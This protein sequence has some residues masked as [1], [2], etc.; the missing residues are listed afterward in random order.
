MP[1]LELNPT[2]VRVF[3]GTPTGIDE[4][5]FAIDITTG[6]LYFTDPLTGTWTLITIGGAASGSS[7]LDF[8]SI[9]DGTVAELTFTVTGAAVND[10]I[11]PSWPSTLDTGLVGM[12]FVS[13][14]DTVTVRLLNMSGAAVDVASSTFGATVF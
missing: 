13:A 3:Y 1:V 4:R 12:M 8:G 9:D 7:T 5:Q 6:N 2:D 11:A 10:S 14:A